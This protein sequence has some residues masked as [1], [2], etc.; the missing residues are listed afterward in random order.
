MNQW[1]IS[2]DGAA[3]CQGTLDPGD[4]LGTLTINE[5]LLRAASGSSV[6]TLRILS[7]RWQRAPLLLTHGRSPSET[8]TVIFRERS[9][10]TETFSN[11]GWI[12]PAPTGSRLLTTPLGGSWSSAMR[13][14]AP[15]SLRT[16]CNGWG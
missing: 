9:S 3:T 11:G 8:A 4:S 1:H 15:A 5:L 16:P 7:G 10:L 12:L 2:D 6:C 14:T 13:A